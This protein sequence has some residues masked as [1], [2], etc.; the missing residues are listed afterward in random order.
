MLEARERKQ[1]DLLGGDSD[2]EVVLPIADP[3][4]G[5]SAAVAVTSELCWEAQIERANE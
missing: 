4:P 2:H 3:D 1:A 5:H